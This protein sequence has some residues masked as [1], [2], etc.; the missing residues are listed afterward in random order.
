MA[1]LARWPRLNAISRKPRLML[2]TQVP[3]KV[4][5]AASDGCELHLEPLPSFL[6]LTHLQRNWHTTERCSGSA[7][8]LNSCRAKKS[9]TLTWPL[10]TR[11]ATQPAA[12]PMCAK[13]SPTHHPQA[14]ASEAI[15]KRKAKQSGVQS[16][17]SESQQQQDRL[18]AQF[19]Q[20]A[21]APAK[22]AGAGVSQSILSRVFQS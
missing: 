21:T 3:L 2:F 6:V 18:S 1:A 7:N 17:V 5:V 8:R 14:R 10:F 11:Y 20:R 19:R 13:P 4:Q 22:G 9:G 12:S 16:T 15:R